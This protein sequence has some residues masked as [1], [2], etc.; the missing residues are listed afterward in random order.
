MSEYFYLPSL[1]MEDKNKNNLDDQ[2]DVLEKPKKPRSEA[3]IAA[4]EKMLSARKT[5]AEM[6]LNE[7]AN[8][9]EKHR[10]E[11]ARLRELVTERIVKKAINIKKKRQTKQDIIEKVLD[12]GDSSEEDTPA[13]LP[14]TQ[15]AV[16]SAVPSALGKSKP[17]PKQFQSIQKPAPQPVV[18]PTPLA[19][20]T[21]LIF[22]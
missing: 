16:R 11:E 13:V 1:H 8:R 2:P 17:A 15:A 6:Q 19:E 10:E 22:F 14:V 7:R 20:P 12:S 18:K 5:K 4:T 21:K 3:Q 9:D